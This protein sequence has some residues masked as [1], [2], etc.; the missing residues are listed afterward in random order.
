[1]PEKA[2]WAPPDALV[3]TP[4]R[5]GTAAPASSSRVRSKGA[6]RSVSPRRNSEVPRGDVASVEAALRQ[7]ALLSGLERDEADRRGVEGGAAPQPDRE[8][9]GLL[10]GSTSGQRCVRSPSAAS[11][12]VRRRR[13]SR[14]CGDPGQAREVPRREDDRVVR[15]PAPAPGVGRVAE[16]LRGPPAAVEPAELAFREEAD[17]LAVGRPE[18]DVAP[19]RSRGTRRLE[20]DREARGPRA[21]RAVARDRRGACRRARR[22]QADASPVRQTPSA[23]AEGASRMHRSRRRRAAG[24]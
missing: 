24:A 9:H 1:M 7:H 5:S 4:S 21:V 10:P 17:R 3:R 19:L 23:P 15:G 16:R 12:D 20:C 22:D 6:A 14:R 18:R 2:R 13:G 11:G 8:E